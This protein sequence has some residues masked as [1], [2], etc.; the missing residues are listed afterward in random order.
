[1][2]V[3]RQTRSQPAFADPSQC[4]RVSG[5]ENAYRDQQKK[6][7]ERY[8]ISLLSIKSVEQGSRFAIERDMY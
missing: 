4:E 2:R 1:V 5:G 6:I 3:G 7:V 8:C